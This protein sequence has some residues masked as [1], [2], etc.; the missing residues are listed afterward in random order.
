[1]KIET[2]TNIAFKQKLKDLNS[3]L[4]LTEGGWKRLPITIENF[5]WGMLR[6]GLNEILEKEITETLQKLKIPIERVNAYYVLPDGDIM[7]QD[8]NFMRCFNNP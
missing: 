5:T 7:F 6:D 1:M 8:K 2:L 3:P 4:N